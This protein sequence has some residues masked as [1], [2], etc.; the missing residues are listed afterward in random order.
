MNSIEQIYEHFALNTCQAINI[1]FHIIIIFI[2]IIIIQQ[3]LLKL[4]KS[5]SR[6][7]SWVFRVID[8]VQHW[9]ILYT[10]VWRDSDRFICYHFLSSIV[11]WPV[12]NV[13]RFQVVKLKQVEHT[14]N[15]KRILQSVSFPFLVRL[16]YSFKV[17]SIRI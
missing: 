10:G 16:D 14:L 3:H 9:L 5:H 2:I 11:Y 6:G 4:A 15:E 12:L 1:C 17:N 13:G 8:F 7:R